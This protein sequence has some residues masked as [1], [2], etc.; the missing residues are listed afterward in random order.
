MKRFEKTT[1]VTVFA[2]Q[3][4]SLLCFGSHAV[5]ANLD[6]DDKALKS[7][8][9]APAKMSNVGDTLGGSYFADKK[10]IKES[11]RLQSQL[12]NLREK[13]RSGNITSAKALKQ[14]DELQTAIQKV[15]ADIEKSKV[16][17]EAFKVFTRTSEQVFPL[18]ESRRVIV[19]G[20]KIRLRSWE[21]PGIKCVLE[22]SIVA[23]E[24]PP[25]SMFSEITIQH[26][27]GSAEP[28][29]GTSV[30]DRERKDREF[31]ASEEG[32]KLTP[33]D[34]KYRK[35]ITEENLVFA[36]KYAP[37]HDQQC[38]MLDLNGLSW[39]EGNKNLSI[40]IESKGGQSTHRSQ[41]QRHAM[42]TIHLPECEWVAVR[43]CERGV[44][45]SGLKTN[46]LLTTDGSQKRD[47][48]ARV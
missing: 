38:N 24:E 35:Q 7:T 31:L 29:V 47:F 33:A 44:D 39:K 18:G 42:L 16:L 4:Y 15:R 17:V 6:D 27:L 9:A 19:T 3:L 21:G 37:F 34:Q 28:I 10:L 32:Q 30:E 14:L 11:E 43:G 41:W 45:I 26:Q 46:L 2:V 8:V 5:A 25:A 40:V 20:D 23:K 48:L 13:I 1:L 12:V 22:K 36:A